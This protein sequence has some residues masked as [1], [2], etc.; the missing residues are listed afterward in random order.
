MATSL[1]LSPL[2]RYS[3][4]TVLPGD[5]IPQ[6]FIELEKVWV[7]LNERLNKGITDTEVNRMHARLLLR[8]MIAS[9]CTHSP[10][11]HAPDQ[12]LWVPYLV[13]LHGTIQYW[14][15]IS[16]LHTLIHKFEMAFSKM[17]SWL[18][19]I[20]DPDVYYSQYRSRIWGCVCN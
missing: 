1:P 3:Y 4:Y 11:L 12:D 16:E 17:V 2:F 14:D 9:P 13:K 7:A 10:T 20:P 5:P 8:D 19:T 6:Q 15:N 18:H